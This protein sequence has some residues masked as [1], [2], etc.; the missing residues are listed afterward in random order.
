MVAVLPNPQT[1]AR[2]LGFL[3]IGQ[4]IPGVVA[5]LVGE[6]L[7]ATLG[8]GAIFWASLIAAVL[9]ALVIAFIR[10]VR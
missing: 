7:V 2:D 9:A 1:A 4:T 5:P 10:S 6:A 8:Y 3:S